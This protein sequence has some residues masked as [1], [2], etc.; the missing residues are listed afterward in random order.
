LLSPTGTI[1]EEASLD[2]LDLIGRIRPG[3]TPL[4]LSVTLWVLCV[5]AFFAAFLPARIAASLEPMRAL[6]TE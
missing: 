5:A 2:W 3:A 6:R 1:L 4:I